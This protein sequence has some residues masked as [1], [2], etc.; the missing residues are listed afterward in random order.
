M[1]STVS[2]RS[3]AT[4]DGQPHTGPCR[5]PAGAFNAAAVSGCNANYAISRVVFY[6]CRG[7]RPLSARRLGRRAR[8]GRTTRVDAVQGLSPRRR[9]CRMRNVARNFVGVDKRR[10]LWGASDAAVDGTCGGGAGSGRCV[11]VTTRVKNEI[12]RIACWEK[13]ILTPGSCCVDTPN[14]GRIRVKKPQ[15][16]RVNYFFRRKP[17]LPTQRI[18]RTATRRL[19]S[20]IAGRQVDSVNLTRLGRKGG[21]HA[22]GW[23]DLDSI[24]SGLQNRSSSI[25]RPVCTRRPRARTAQ[26]ASTAL[27]TRALR[28]RACRQLQPMTDNQRLITRGRD[29]N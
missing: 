21:R 17:R 24:V 3:E 10:A 19:P 27:V 9:R 29:G 23:R 8:Q 13:R 22:L 12:D 5:R 15:H 28:D 4:P 26:T 1:A 20:E 2:R 6:D 16:G 18:G 11:H 7:A 25:D 14:N